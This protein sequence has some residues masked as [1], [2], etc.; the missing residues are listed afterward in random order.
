MSRPPL[1]SALRRLSRRMADESTM[2][3]RLSRV[4]I[5]SEATLVVPG[6]RKRQHV[7]EVL[8]S[9]LGCGHRKFPAA[10]ENFWAWAKETHGVIPP[11]CDRK[12]IGDISIASPKLGVDRTIRAF[13]RR[14][15]IQL[16]VIVVFRRERTFTVVDPR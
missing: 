11:V 3:H 5:L 14:Q 1:M 15:S 2:R 13:F 8:A 9:I 10:I 7:V 16:I 6:G 12:A 4:H